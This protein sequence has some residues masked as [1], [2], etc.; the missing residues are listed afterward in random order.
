MTSSLGIFS[1]TKY[2]ENPPD[3]PEAGL[4]RLIGREC[5]RDGAAHPLPRWDTHDQQLILRMLR[6]ISC[7]KKA[8]RPP[9]QDSRDG[10]WRDYCIV[11]VIIQFN[12]T[13]S[14]NKTILNRANK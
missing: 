4:G 5:R 1:T 14:N 10:E 13:L 9:G 6:G 7:I 12:I 8:L 3:P 11:F 2:A